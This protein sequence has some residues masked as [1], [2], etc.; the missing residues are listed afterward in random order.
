MKFVYICIY[1]YST[2]RIIAKTIDHTIMSKDS[3]QIIHSFDYT[4]HNTGLD[5]MRTFQFDF[6]YH[7]KK[8]IRQLKIKLK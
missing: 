7:S 3:L 6:Y 2:P 8:F 1:I 5:E 4:P